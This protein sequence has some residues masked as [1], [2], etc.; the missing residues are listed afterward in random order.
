LRTIILFKLEQLSILTVC[1]SG[2]TALVSFGQE[3]W[4]ITSAAALALCHLCG[5]EAEN[6]E[7]V[8]SCANDRF[9]PGRIFNDRRSVT[10]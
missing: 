7:E 10:G 8:Y 1:F 6:R 9:Q 3:K 2:T 4:Q 5:P